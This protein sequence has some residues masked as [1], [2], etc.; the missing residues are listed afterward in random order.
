MSRSSTPN[1]SRKINIDP[2]VIDPLR[3]RA[4]QATLL[5]EKQRQLVLSAA[6]QPQIRATCRIQ[7]LG[8]Y[9]YA[10]S[11]CIHAILSTMAAQSPADRGRAA[12]QSVPPKIRLINA[13]RSVGT[14]IASHRCAAEVAHRTRDKESYHH[15]SDVADYHLRLSNPAYHLDQSC[16]IMFRRKVTRGS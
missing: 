11:K 5:Q 8:Q 1:T 15:H 6:M 14:C 13:A 3:P 7:Q 12:L 2:A 16:S 9:W 4:T 10:N